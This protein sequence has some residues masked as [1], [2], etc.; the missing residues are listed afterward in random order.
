MK[1]LISIGL[2]AAVLL[3]LCGCQPEINKTYEFKMAY[4]DTGEFT[5]DALIR[6]A[7]EIEM[8][9]GGNVIIGVSPADD[10]STM[11][12]VFMRAPDQFEVYRPFLI[13]DYEEGRSAWIF[14]SDFYTRYDDL[15]AVKGQKLLGFFPAGFLGLGAKEIDAETCFDFSVKKDALL[16]IPESGALRAVTEAMGFRGTPLV[17]SDIAF[18][19][20]TGLVQGWLGGGAQ[21]NFDEFRDVIEYYV[22]YRYAND[23]FAVLIKKELF[24]SLPPEYQ[25][26]ITQSF[27]T[28]SMAAIDER[29]ALDERALADLKNYGV[30][31]LIP[32]REERG[33]MAATLPR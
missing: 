5:G 14:G 7:G 9:T 4:Q 8:L 12:M 16:S 27:M 24:D 2:A 21:T 22:D 10:F 13:T 25:D 30:T 18:A 6:A 31:V 3:I 28:E 20:K 29:E 11:D 33:A 32:T 15:L 23:L 26:A 19:M 1:K 17:F